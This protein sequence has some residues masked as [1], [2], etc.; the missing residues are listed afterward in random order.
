MI[1]INSYFKQLTF[2]LLKKE[3][4]K[5]SIINNILYIKENKNNINIINL[6][7]KNY[8]EYKILTK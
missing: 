3:N 1:K 5:L 6:L 4:V 2:M 7:N 8:I